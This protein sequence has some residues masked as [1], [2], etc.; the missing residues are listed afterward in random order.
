MKTLIVEIL[1]KNSELNQELLEYI[2]DHLW[3]INK[4]GYSFKI[5]FC[6]ADGKTQYPRLNLGNGQPYIGTN[7]IK[8]ALRTVSKP[9]APAYEDGEDLVRQFQ[10]SSMASG[11]DDDGFDESMKP[12]TMQDRMSAIMSE[13]GNRSGGK[14]PSPPPRRSRDEPDNVEPRTKRQHPA[15]KP[16]SRLKSQN[17]EIAGAFSDLKRTAPGGDAAKDDAMM[18]NWL[19]NQEES[20]F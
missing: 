20:N 19:A 16:G 18:E 12:G 15:S 4:A 11:D 14:E 1:R 8:A 5:C 17:P 6:K 9:Q 2:N 10:M 7:Q 13:R 3:T